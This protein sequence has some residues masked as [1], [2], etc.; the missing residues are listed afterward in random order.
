[1][2]VSLFIVETGIFVFLAW[3]D[4]RAQIEKKNWE[5]VFRSSFIQQYPLPASRLRSISLIIPP[6]LV[7]ADS[8]VG[9]R[10]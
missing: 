3:P 9:Q 6:R 7:L 5:A 1:M 10:Y 2:A 8:L 4:V